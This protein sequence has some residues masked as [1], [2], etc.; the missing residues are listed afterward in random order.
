MLF[1]ESP[2]VRVECRLSLNTTQLNSTQ[3]SKS[4]SRLQKSK[5]SRQ[6]VRIR[7]KSDLFNNISRF[8]FFDLYSRTHTIYL[9]YIKIE[10]L[11]IKN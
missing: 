1:L 7:D 11:T 3:L 10:I 2:K 5:D 9:H 8:L 4:K 6:I